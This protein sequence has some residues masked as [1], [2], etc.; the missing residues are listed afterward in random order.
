MNFL[1]SYFLTATSATLQLLDEINNIPNIYKIVFSCS[2][3]QSCNTRYNSKKINNISNCLMILSGLVA[4]S[5][6]WFYVF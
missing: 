4:D 2:W 5:M 1:L 3:L 6:Y